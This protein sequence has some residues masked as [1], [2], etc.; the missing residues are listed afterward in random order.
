M[1]YIINYESIVFFFNGKP[2]KVLKDSPQYPQIIKAFDLPDSERDAAIDALLQKKSGF[3]SADGFEITPESVSYN[4]EEIP[5]PLASKVRYIAEEGL[6]VKLFSKFWENLQ[7][8]SS[9]SSVRQ[10]YDFL[11]YK[12]LPITDDGCFLA[13]KGLCSD[14]WSISGNLKTKVI[15]GSVDASGRILNT[16]GTEIEV[17]RWDV[18]D[19]R[20][21]HCSFGL[22]VGSLDY[23]NGFSQGHVVVVKV[24]PKDVV[25]VPSDYNCQKCRVSAYKVIDSFETEIKAPITDESGEPLVSED[26]EEYNAFEEDLAELINDLLDHNVYQLAL[27]DIQDLFEDNYYYR[28]SEVRLLD[29]LKNGNYHWSADQDDEVMVFL[30]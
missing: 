3:F 22:H 20:E 16:V 24:N 29:T 15:K 1:T 5:D 25:S 26:R 17:R 7:Q 12:E 13:Y 8:N 19:N 14:M 27:S 30:G 21:N 9:A 2:L 28:P 4:G 10:L 6:P 23:A 18:D 11:S